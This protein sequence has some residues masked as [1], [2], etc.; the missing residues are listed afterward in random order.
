MDS[1]IHPL[2]NPSSHPSHSSQSQSQS[3][4]SSQ[5]SLKMPI[6]TFPHQSKPTCLIC[7][8]QG[9]IAAKELEGTLDRT[10]SANAA[11]GAPSTSSLSSIS[12]EFLFCQFCLSPAHRSCATNEGMKTNIGWAC[13]NCRHRVD[14]Q[15]SP[16]AP[17]EATPTPLPSTSSISNIAPVPATGSIVPDMKQSQPNPVS[18]DATISAQSN[19]LNDSTVLMIDGQ[20]AYEVERIMKQR[21]HKGQRQVRR[22]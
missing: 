4:H 1:V 11:A 6:S 19:S 7:V 20:P 17:F 3:L 14:F 21:V 15:P 8:K 2:P 16:T 9:T 22:V 10:T 18:L 5:F 13:N 12:D